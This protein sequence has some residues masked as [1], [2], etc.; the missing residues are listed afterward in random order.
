MD[1]TVKSQVRH[2]YEIE[3]LTRRQIAGKLGICRNRVGKI[4]AGEQMIGP[5][6]ATLMTP[7]ERIIDEWYREYPFLRATQIYE[8]LREHAYQG[9]Y[10]IVCDYTRRYRIKRRKAYHELEF[11][12][13]EEAQVDWMEQR[14]PF[15]IAYGFV[16]ILSWS[17]HLY[18]RFYPRHTLEFF[19]DGHCEAFREIGGIASR[20]RYDNLKSVVISRKPDLRLNPDFMD[21]ARHYGFSIYPCNPYRANEKGRVE[22]VIR[23]IRTFLRVNAFTDLKDLNKKVT[24]WRIQ[25]NEKIH[26]TTQKI[27][28][29]S[30]KEEKLKSLPVIPY[31]PY[32]AVSAMVSVTGFIE[33]DTNRY[34]VPTDYVEKSASIAAFPEQIEIR[35]GTKTVATHKRLFGKRQKIEHPDHRSKLL[36][37]TPEFKRQRIY[38]LMKN[39]DKSLEQFIAEADSEGQEPLDV[40][41]ELFKIMRN[42]SRELLLSAIRQA[43]ELKISKV[44]YIM[45][46]LRLPEVKQDNPVHPQNTKLLDITYE[47]RELGYYDGLI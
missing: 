3:G 28:A 1:E 32:R 17:R 20:N 10:S 39:M 2:L 34:S 44:K 23:D 25:R 40:A 37:M 45:S 11:L 14:F 30:L 6:P 46:V 33:F 15:G 4:I 21:F 22:R 5:V 8:R 43:N 7:Y 36:S 16:F 35:I 47:G 19:L 13:G 29:E 27:P 38:Q 9:G 12:P 24:A 18:V 31:R 26:R 41:Y 42:S